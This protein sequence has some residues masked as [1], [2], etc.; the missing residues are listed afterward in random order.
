MNFDITL[1]S[2]THPILF[3]ISVFA[4]IIVVLIVIV[5]AYKL[6]NNFIKKGGSIGPVTIEHD[7][8]LEEVQEKASNIII[9]KEIQFVNCLSAVINAS[10]DCG[11]QKSVERQNLFTKQI[12]YTKSRFNGIIS[13][14]TIQYINTK[15]N[16]SIKQTEVLLSHIFE[17]AIYIPLER[18]FKADRLIEKSKENI[19]EEQRHFIDNIGL[20]V[21]KKTAEYVTGNELYNDLT[22]A[23][24]SKED[25]LKRATLDSIEKAYDYAKT[26]MQQINKIQEDLNKAIENALSM[27]LGE[28]F[29]ELKTPKNWND[30]LPPNDIIGEI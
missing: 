24:K 1:F 18:I 2:S 14:I 29:S 7:K 26:E 17:Q 30:D 3:S 21:L 12:G 22:E 13:S 8:I 23:I 20:D 5:L 9:K 27:Y 19:I 25:E 10:V 11:F 16:F 4:I 28:G 6:V 15:R